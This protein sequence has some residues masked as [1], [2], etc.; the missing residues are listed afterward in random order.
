MDHFVFP[1]LDLASFQHIRDVGIE[2]GYSCGA[3][4][5]NRFV[6]HSQGHVFTAARL[7]EEAENNLI[8]GS[9][10]EGRWLPKWESFFLTC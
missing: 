10:I 5:S 6:L 7:V 1:A 4:T 3:D 2:I 8:T 9:T